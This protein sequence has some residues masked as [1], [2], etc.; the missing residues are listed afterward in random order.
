MLHAEANGITVVV[1]TVDV[2]VAP[3]TV[4]SVNLLPGGAN[5]TVTIFDGTTGVELEQLLQLANGINLHV[6]YPRGLVCPNGIRVTVTGAGA[7]A[8]LT[9]NK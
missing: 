1:G 6:I 5:A 3:G 4:W 7:K 8:H 9:Y 2:T